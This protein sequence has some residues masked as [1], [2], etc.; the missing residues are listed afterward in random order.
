M[1]VS[2]L[3]TFPDFD[4]S[5]RPMSASPLFTPKPSLVVP[6]RPNDTFYVTTPTTPRELDSQRVGSNDIMEIND[7]YE[8]DD[9]QSVG[10]I[11]DEPVIPTRLV[12]SDLEVD[13]APVENELSAPDDGRW[14][15]LPGRPDSERTVLVLPVNPNQVVFWSRD[16]KFH[17]QWELEMRMAQQS[18][19]Q[20][21]DLHLSDLAILEGTVAEALPK[22]DLVMQAGA[23]RAEFRDQDSRG[24]RPAPAQVRAREPQVSKLLHGQPG[25]TSSS[26]RRMCTEADRE[27]ASIR[28]QDGKGSYS[29]DLDW[30]Y[31][32]K[33][34][35]TVYVRPTKGPLAAECGTPVRLYSPSTITTNSPTAL[36]FSMELRPP[37]MT[38]K[39]FHLARKYGSRRIL[40]FKFADINDP[41]ARKEMFDLFEGRRFVLAGRVFRAWS[42]A[43]DKSSLVAIEINE[44][45]PGITH[46]TTKERHDPVMPTFLEQL[47]SSN[48]LSLKPSQAMA[49][50]AS[51][52]QLL[53]S[54]SYP[55]VCLLPSDVHVIDD[56]VVAGL[57]EAPTTEQ[58][59]TDGCGLMTEAV[60]RQIGLRLPS[61][62]GRPCVVQMRLMGAKGLLVLM[63]PDQ[64]ILYSGKQVI[65]RKSM[66]KSLTSTR[67]ASQYIIEVVRCG[68]NVLKTSAALPS[69]AIIALNSRKVPRRT[70]IEKAELAFD[71]L[72][73][74]F[75][76]TPS[77]TETSSDVRQRLSAGFYRTG[78]VG[79]ERKKRMC[80]DK[81]LSLRVCGL[82][83]DEQDKPILDNGD[84][85]DE[86]DMSGQPVQL[87][88]R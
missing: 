63:S 44:S 70:L 60:A 84:Q 19:V 24:D 16:V 53:L 4:F 76:P 12:A 78:G 23:L 51:R 29:D 59:L 28:A 39:S 46:P 87:A 64:E 83:R 55:A 47:A 82:I 17:V 18:A 30:K 79:V 2:P 48:D 62:H 50:W 72:R 52:P 81:A 3:P 71:D 35:Y 58:T 54:D 26:T 10:S 5:Q 88:E 11:P 15:P 21:Q 9:W 33:L 36:A 66:V 75:D 40:N 74:Q 43:T 49:K 1:S 7:I 22:I 38:G 57:S 41:Q 65:L 80:R 13:N 67:T 56:I 61:S 31:G 25:M 32:G 45:I 77:G 86:E 34:I 69:E 6:D 42:A 68:H 27:E 8:D 73:T 20:W 85:D 14:R 37:T